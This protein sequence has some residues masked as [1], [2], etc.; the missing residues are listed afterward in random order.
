MG[1]SYSSITSI[2]RSKAH[3]T[4]P[5]NIIIG[6]RDLNSIWYPKNVICN[7]KY[8]IITFIP[9]VLFRQF[10]FFLNLYF[11]IMALTQFIPSLRIAP[12]YTYWAPLGFV[13][14]VSMIREGYDDIKRAYRDKE[15]NSEM[16]TV[17]SE[18]G[19]KKEIPSSKIQVSDVIIIKKNQRVPADVVLLQTS[20]KSGE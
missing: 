19:Q 18:D 6:R 10:N 5:R 20:D 2:C 12:L 7:Q 1:V 13:I 11:L 16:Y 15:L 14:S 4:Q 9:L 8:N 3:K 17:L